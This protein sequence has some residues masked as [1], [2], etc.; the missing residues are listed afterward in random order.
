[1]TYRFSTKCGICHRDTQA[2]FA[3]TKCGMTLCS[4]HVVRDEAGIPYCP[5]CASG[6]SPETAKLLKL[7]AI[8]GLVLLALLEMAAPQVVK[9][10]RKFIESLKRRGGEPG[11]RVNLT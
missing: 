10:V 9:A 1:M 6:R 11:G 3:C 2:Q 8:V 7:L 5:Y 4:R